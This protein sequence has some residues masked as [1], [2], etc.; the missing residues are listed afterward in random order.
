[1][2]KMRQKVKYS[3]ILLMLFTVAVKAQENLDISGYA[4]NYTG[5]LT[6]GDNDFSIIQNT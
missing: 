1:M 3:L 2:N 4:R 5:V 6:G